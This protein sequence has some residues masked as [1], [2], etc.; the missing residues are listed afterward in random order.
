MKLISLNT[1]GGSAGI[2]QLLAFFDAHRNVDF[3]CLQEVWNG[4]DHMFEPNPTGLVLRRTHTQLLQRITSTLTEHQG[5]FRPNFFDFYGLATFVKQGIR[6]LAEGEFFVHKERGFY[7]K[8]IMSKHARNIQYVTYES[9]GEKRTI[10]NFHG[11]WEE[12]KGDSEDRLS[13]SEKILDFLGNLD[14]PHVICGD[15]NLSLH[16]ESLA[17]MERC[18]LRNLIKDF[19]IQS[20]R[21]SY[22]KEER[23]ADY[24]LVSQGM[25]VNAFRVL[26]DEVSDHLALYAEIG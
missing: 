15:F 3:F 22:A 6:V 16:T 18:G 26:P 8:E 21:S 14:H 13:Q 10:V 1:W 5:Y 7:S 25:E 12:G 19:G 9:E 23:F 20:T 17:K 11:L 24:A 4:G 2:D